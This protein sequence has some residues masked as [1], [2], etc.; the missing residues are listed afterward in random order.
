M[1]E[2][3]AHGV[4]QPQRECDASP[5]ARLEALRADGAAHV[6]PARLRY[7]DLLAGRAATEP[8][9]VRAILAGKLDSALER[10]EQRFRQAQQATRDELA[11]L[12]S[13]HPGLA[14]ELRRLFAAGDY[15]AARRLAAQA[16]SD[17][18]C[19]HMVRLNEYLGHATGA[20]GHPGDAPQARPEMK[21]VRRF[22]ETWSR[23]ASEDQVDQAVGRGPENAGP[24][25][26]HALILQS[27]A[28]MRTLSPDYL[29][30]FLSHVDSLLWLDHA[31]Q[32]C[33]PVA[34][35]P[36]TARTGR[37]KKG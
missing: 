35:K 25:N 36:K 30:R 37:A 18:H 13:R 26:S 32:A 12:A 28:M 2:S 6:D 23:I 29:R 10:F 15:R 8:E 17:T 11:N 9:P 21:S 7:L 22:R 24:L 1:S 20:G 19:T 27:L 14:R 16:A 3:G 31:N 4:Q 5:L 33:K 34:P